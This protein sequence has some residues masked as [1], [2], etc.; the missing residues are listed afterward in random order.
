MNDDTKLNLLPATMNKVSSP[1][2]KFDITDHGCQTLACLTIPFHYL[3]CCPGFLGRKT[4]ILEDEEVVLTVRGGCCD[5][6][7]RRPYGE[8]GSVDRIRVFCCVGFSSSLFRGWVICPGCGR[9]EN[10]VVEVV[11]EL[12]KRMKN[13]GDTGNIRRVEQV[14]SELDEVRTDLKD[15]K[16]DLQVVLHALN[17]SKTKPVTENMIR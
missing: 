8:L 5:I 4:L 14:L 17:K 11:E 15:V 1:S 10:L 2:L 7:T 9:N 12:Q 13:R 6:D 3:P 16:A